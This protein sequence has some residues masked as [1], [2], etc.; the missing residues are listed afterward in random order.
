[1]WTPLP[2]TMLCAGWYCFPF[3]ALSPRR[4][5]KGIGEA[6]GEERGASCSPGCDFQRLQCA[7]RVPAASASWR[8]RKGLLLRDMVRVGTELWTGTHKGASILPSWLGV[9]V[10]TIKECWACRGGSVT[11]AVGFFYHHHPSHYYYLHYYYEH[12]LTSF[13][14]K[15]KYIYIYTDPQFIVWCP[16]GSSGMHFLFPSPHMCWLSCSLGSLAR[17]LTHSLIQP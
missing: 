9:E 17:L 3:L 7:A 1:M 10:T 11:I 8:S 16:W 6:P 13:N 2:Q 4:Q 14:S 15:K 5:Q 12:C